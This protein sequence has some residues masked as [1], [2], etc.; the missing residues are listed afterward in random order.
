M[1]ALLKLTVPFVKGITFHVEVSH[2]LV[3]LNFILGHAIWIR[4]T[5][6]TNEEVHKDDENY[7]LIEDPG[8]LDEIDHKVT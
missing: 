8:K 3:L 6:K 2:V 7:K 4:L 1:A 5:D